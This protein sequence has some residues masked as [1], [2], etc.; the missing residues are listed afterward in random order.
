MKKIT[1]DR[2]VRWHVA[3]QHMSERKSGTLRLN[4]VL[5]AMADEIMLWRGTEKFQH[6]I[7]ALIRDEWDRRKDEVSEAARSRVS[8]LAYAGRGKTTKMESAHTKSEQGARGARGSGSR[9]GSGQPSSSS[10]K[11]RG[12][13]SK[14]PPLPKG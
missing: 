2:K 12:N 9:A 1:V 11:A 5:A 3:N 13:R 4:A 6:F 7:E 14:L 10:D 8:A